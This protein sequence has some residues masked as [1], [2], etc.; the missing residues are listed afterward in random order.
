MDEVVAAPVN[1][2]WHGRLPLGMLTILDGDPALGKSTIAIDVAARLSSGRPFPGSCD[3]TTAEAVAFLCSED[4]AEHTVRPRL[5]AAGADL[6]RCHVIDTVSTGD[7]AR[8][9]ILPADLPF[10]EAFSAAN[11]VKL[12]VIDPLFGFVAAELDS[13]KDHSIRAVL[14]AIK[15]T[16]ERTGAAVLA[17]RHLNKGNGGAALYRG[18]GSIAITAQ[19][20]VV[21][22]VGRN[23]NRQDERLLAVAKS[24]L[25]K[26]PKALAYDLEA[27]AVGPSEV[28]R[29]AWGQESDL[30]A[31]DIVTRPT[32]DGG[33]GAA[34]V[35][36]EAFLRDELA[37]GPVP[38]DELTSRAEAKG[39]AKRTLYRAK[40]AVGV[41]ASK[42]GFSGGW[43]WEL[44]AEGGRP[45]A[46]GGRDAPTASTWPSSQKS[47]DF[48]EGGQD[49]QPPATW[50]HSEP[51]AR[52]RTGRTPPPTDDIETM[53]RRVG[54]TWE[55]VGEWFD[56][57]GDF[58]DPAAR[59]S[60]L[61]TPQREALAAHLRQLAAERDGR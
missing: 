56:R 3:P 52:Q 9:I 45:V 25:A 41:K 60:G 36:A 1:W 39:I 42:G 48:A 26:T 32:P 11:G 51:P 24:N 6:T 22:S 20:R 31:D 13:H 2:L 23:P 28:S 38:S 8:P 15:L 59:S 17:L 19:A 44:P 33:K 46:E 40:E 35:E 50:P 53:L 61:T 54:W 58:F 27:V 57:R 12:I 5:E 37:A 29:V 30:T 21:L 55:Q 16:A 49:G 10:I 7:T 43:R 14:H 47:V 18:G 34:L 4:S